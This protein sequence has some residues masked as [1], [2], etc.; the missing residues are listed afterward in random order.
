V[1]ALAAGLLVWMWRSA[2]FLFHTPA[3]PQRELVTGEQQR[4]TARVD[5]DP[6]IQVATRS[7]V[8]D[9][10]PV[11]TGLTPRDETPD[12]DAISRCLP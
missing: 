10:N 9:A 4:Q 5:D 2:P 1:A 12:G 6:G 11:A 3:L 8:R 7:R